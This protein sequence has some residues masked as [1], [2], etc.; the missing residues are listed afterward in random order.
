MDLCS[1]TFRM[2]SAN[3]S[4]TEMILILELCFFNGMESVK[5]TSSKADFSILS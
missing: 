1:K 4:A 3:I 2:V 5:I